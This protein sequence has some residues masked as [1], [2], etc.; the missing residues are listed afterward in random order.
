MIRTFQQELVAGTL[1]N[2]GPLG[3]GEESI[4]PAQGHF[5][6]RVYAFL[7]AFQSFEKKILDV[8]FGN[9]E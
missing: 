7:S 2:H 1:A 3:F 8:R 5:L 9:L 4:L 6:G